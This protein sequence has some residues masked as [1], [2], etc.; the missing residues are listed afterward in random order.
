MVLVLNC[1]FFCVT[2]FTFDLYAAAPSCHAYKE[3]GYCKYVGKVK[4]I[5]VNSSNIILLY[6]D[7]PVDVSQSQEYGFN[8]SYYFSAAIDITKISEF[9]SYF[10]SAK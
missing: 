4:S 9:E 2:F 1:Y 5:Y 10:Y 7:T 8:I 3:S 6:F